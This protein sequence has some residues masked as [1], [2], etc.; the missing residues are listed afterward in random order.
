MWCLLC[1][2]RR[3]GCCGQLW[4]S[5]KWVLPH[6]DLQAEKA[7]KQ[8]G[9]LHNGPRASPGWGR[10]REGHSLEDR[11]VGQGGRR[12]GQVRMGSDE[13]S[14]QQRKQ[15]CKGPEPGQHQPEINVAEMETGREAAE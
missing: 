3:G 5:Q 8:I 4:T 9:R 14:W 2:R 10:V 13:Q 1:A 11:G 12:L 7:G 15:C 6:T